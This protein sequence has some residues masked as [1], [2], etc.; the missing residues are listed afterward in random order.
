VDQFSGGGSTALKKGLNQMRKYIKM[1]AAIA[2][3][4]IPFSTA[5]ASDAQGN[6]MAYGIGGAPCHV[7]LTVTERERENYD[8][9]LTGFLTASNA[10]FSGTKDISANNSTKF[11]SIVWKQCKA[12]HDISITEAALTIAN[13]L[14]DRLI[15]NPNQ[16][17]YEEEER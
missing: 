15:A 14:H 9:W 17:P 8:H 2:A 4:S 11:L 7:F 3:I 13:R 6:Y 12:F 10:I 5:V 1:T 16:N